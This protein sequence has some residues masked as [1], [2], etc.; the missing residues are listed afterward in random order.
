VHGDEYDGQ[1]AVRRL[2]PLL[3][4]EQ[5]HG[6]II[7]IPCVN[8]SAF[9][10]DTRESSV[11]GANFNRIFP[12]S[13]DG[14]FSNRLAD[15]YVNTI[16]PAADAMVDIHTGGAYGQIAPLTVVQGGFEELA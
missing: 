1:E 2:F 7:A 8:E 13:P 3:D 14:T 9:V 12:G 10:S 6:T 15:L 11:D 4:P 16:I 5:M